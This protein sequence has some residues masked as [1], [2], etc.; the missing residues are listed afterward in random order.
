M[1]RH[2]PLRTVTHRY[3]PS[4]HFAITFLQVASDW[5]F[6]L[7]CAAFLPPADVDALGAAIV[8]VGIGKK[9]KA[10][11]ART[12]KLICEYCNLK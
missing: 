5:Q 8:A 7:H 10:A 1:H 2:A 9:A 6:L 4:R 11:L 3:A 12:E